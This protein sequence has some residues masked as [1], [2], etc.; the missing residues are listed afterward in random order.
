MNDKIIEMLS[1]CVNI[2]SRVEGVWDALINFPD[3][4]F[5]IDRNVTIEDYLRSSYI[6]LLIQNGKAPKELMDLY[7]L[8]K[9]LGNELGKILYEEVMKEE[10]DIIDDFPRKRELT[11]KRLFI[12]TYLDMYG[13]MS[14]KIDYNEIL[15]NHMNSL[16][17]NVP[18]KDVLKKVLKTYNKSNE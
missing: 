9:K 16:S 3:F 7:N 18:S 12:R 2:R 6:D 1:D 14:L 8:Y 11:N 15:N 5:S 10:D 13:V 17:K 4:D